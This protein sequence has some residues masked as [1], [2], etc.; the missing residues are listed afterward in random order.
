MATTL[1]DREKRTTTSWGAGPGAPRSRQAPRLVFGLA[2]AALSALLGTWAFPPYGLWPLIFVAWVPMLVA[3]HHVLPRRWGWVA[4]GIGIGG[5]YVGYLHGVV[6]GGF[7]WWGACIPLAVGLVAGVAAM[8]DRPLQE[9]SGYV[10]FVFAFPLGWAAAEFLRGFVPAL[11]TQGW[12]A[13]ALFREPQLLQPVSVVGTA[14]LNLLIFV[15]NWTIALAVLVALDRMRSRPRRLISTRVLAVSGLACALAVGVWVSSSLFMF[16]AAPPTVTVAAIQPGIHTPGPVDLSRDIAQTRLAA[17]KGAKLVV[18]QEGTLWFKPQ[19]T[20][21]GAELSGLARQSHIY[22]V[23]GYK[24]VTARGQHNDATVIAPSGR[25][26][27]V[28]GK[29]HPAIMFGDDQTSVDAGTMPVYQTP[30]G[31]LATM[32][33]FDADFTDTARSAA[34][35]GAQILAVPTWDWEG[36]APKHY[37]LLV[38]RAIE[39]R[40]TIVKGE[41]SY[42][43]VVIDPY[44]RMLA[45][46]ITPKGT[47]ETILARVPVGMG[48]T[49]LV[50]LGNLWGWLIVAGAVSTL[51][52]APKKR[53]T[54][55]AG[56]DAGRG[57]GTP[58]ND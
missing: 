12:V 51:V 54:A 46:A 58:S 6:S 45:S 31:R 24:F 2:L 33:C 20:P 13:Y 41:F 42:D 44:G 25:Y 55:V 43:S 21:V 37:G 22:L 35:H 30:F 29:Q 53:Q 57:N 27:G 49:P 48:K 7:A 26:L 4:V 10:R 15:V 56:L 39:N 11:G 36:Q 23:V 17:S 52:I 47:E 5:Y 3:Q 40:L 50:S 1:A 32:I 19:G 16:R 38:F 14:A 28:Y 18:W 8:A 9:A 34:L